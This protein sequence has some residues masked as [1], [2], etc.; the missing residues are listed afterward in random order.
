MGIWNEHVSNLSFPAV[1]LCYMN[2]H[3]LSQVQKLGYY[4]ILRMASASIEDYEGF[5]YNE[6]VGTEHLT[7][8]F[9]F[10]MNFTSISVCQRFCND[11][12]FFDL[13]C[14]GFY[15]YTFEKRCVLT[16]YTG[17]SK[18]QYC[19]DK[20]T[21]MTIMYFTKARK[22]HS[23]PIY[24]TF[25]DDIA[26]GACPL[27]SDRNYK[28]EFKR[29][30]RY[31]FDDVTLGFGEVFGIETSVFYTSLTSIAS[32]MTPSMNTTGKCLLFLYLAVSFDISVL[33]VSFES[34]NLEN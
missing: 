26:T 9:N 34:E 3:R 27:L 24:C 22:L 33:Q 6:S 28:E 29:M 2:L 30:Y 17:V 1:I 21:N 13:Q 15:W 8:R 10:T 18:E 31:E 25:A 20:N 16:S 23:K 19:T 11:S 14:N 5:F 7:A 32:F 12:H 4:D